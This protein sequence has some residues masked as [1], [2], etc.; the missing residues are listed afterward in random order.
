MTASIQNIGRL[1][2][3]PLSRLTRTWRRSNTG[4]GQ[5]RRRRRRGVEWNV[6]ITG[7]VVRVA[8]VVA[9]GRGVRWRMSKRGR[10]CIRAV[11]PPVK[12]SVRALH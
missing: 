5:R 3:T 9:L 8:H 4:V 7:E 12:R 6:S 11:F 1:M 2:N 10:L